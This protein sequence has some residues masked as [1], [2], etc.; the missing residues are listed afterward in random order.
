MKTATIDASV[1][2]ELKDAVAQL[3]EISGQSVSSI[4]EE[5]L[6]QYLS[7]RVPQM[8]DLREAIA[9]A[10]RGEFASDEEVNAF[11]AR[12]WT[13][14]SLSDISRIVDYVSQH[15]PAA[16]MKLAAAIRAS[17]EHLRC[18]CPERRAPAR[19]LSLTLRGH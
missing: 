2:E 13:H 1:P 10:D 7:W 15:D 16:A 9:A 3:S 6:R 14:R 8:L 18:G 12:R 5:A 17:A 4:T 11:F 19:K